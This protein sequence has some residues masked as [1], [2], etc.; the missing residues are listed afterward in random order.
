M[1][2]DGLYHNEWLL[3]S[4]TP[5]LCPMEAIAIPLPKYLLYYFPVHVAKSF[6][7][8]EAAP[9]WCGSQQ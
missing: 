8:A 7:E 5:L 9:S 1:Y 4:S 6:K 2:V 3:F